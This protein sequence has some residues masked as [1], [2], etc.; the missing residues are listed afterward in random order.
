[1]LDIYFLESSKFWSDDS[2]IGQVELKDQYVCRA[3]FAK[4]L[5]CSEDAK[6]LTGQ[7]LVTGVERALKC[8]LEGIKVALQDSRYVFLLY[9]ASV[10]YW[11][12]SRPLQKSGT[13]RHLVDA[14]TSV[15]DALQKVSGHEE[16]KAHHLRIHAL[17]LSDAGK[18]ADALKVASDAVDLCKANVPELSVLAIKMKSHVSSL[19]G[20]KEGGDG[21]DGA[22]ALMQHVRSGACADIED[23]KNTLI[24]AWKL[25][26]PA[27]EK[28]EAAK[29]ESA[30]DAQLDVVAE[31]GWIAAQNQV[32]DLAAWCLERAADDSSLISRVRDEMTRGMIALHNL[33]EKRG[34]LDSEAIR[35]HKDVILE[36]EKSL[37]TFSR[38]QDFDGIHDACQMIW[39]ASLPLQQ[40]KFRHHLTR[41][42][43]AAALALETVGSSAN[44]LRTSLHLEL[45]YCYISEDMVGQAKAQVSKGLAIDYVAPAEEIKSTGYER[46]LDRFLDPLHR[47]L[48]LKSKIH[49]DPD[50]IED[51]ALLLAE[52][53]RDAKSV[54]SK[55]DIL[56]RAVDA[57]M[58]LQ[59]AT[60]P[61]ESD[62][63]STE[64]RE[65]RRRSARARINIWGSVIKVAMD[66]KQI[67]MVHR[68]AK[69]VV[70]TA[71]WDLIK[72]KD[73]ILLQADVNLLDGLASF[74]IL[75]SRGE[76]IIPPNE[77]N[78][79]VTITTGST[80]ELQNNTIAAFVR[81]MHLGA[82]VG[83]D[84]V[85]L[86]AAANVW[87]NYLDAFTAHRYAE[88]LPATAPVFAEL[89]KV[90]CCDE[91]LLGNFADALSCGYEHAAF[92]SVTDADDTKEDGMSGYNSL[93]LTLRDHKFEDSQDVKRGIETC[94]SVLNRVD[95]RNARKL[96]ATLARLHASMGTSSE[97]KVEE[98][99]VAQVSAIIQRLTLPGSDDA[100]S[101]MLNEAMTL[102][103]PTEGEI[104]GDLETWAR[105]GETALKAKV[106]GAA[107]ECGK[108]AEI[109][110]NKL[111]QSAP[112]ISW[113]WG[114]VAESTFGCGILAL[115]RPDHQDQ[116]T[117]DTLRE[118]AFQHLVQAAKCGRRANRSDIVSYAAKHFWNSA[119]SYM[120]SA[121]TR[122]NI[123]GHLQV[124][125]DACR[126]TKVR[127]DG[128][129]KLMWVLYFDCLVDK[130]AWTDG[131]K[132][133]DEA[134][135]MLP[136]SD[137][138]R[139]WEYKVLFL[140]ATGRKA[141]DELDMLSSYDEET[142][143]KVW[144][145]VAVQATSKLE[146]M[147]AYRKAIDVLV[148][149]TAMRVD[150]MID[151]ADWMYAN[152]Q[153]VS[154]AEDLL[155]STL[156]ILL[157]TDA[158]S[159]GDN[160]DCESLAT[161]Q[162]L[163]VTEFCFI[164]RVCVM[165]SRMSGSNV[166]RT[167]YLLTAQHY[168]LRM[169]LDPLAEA[170]RTMPASNIEGCAATPE[171]MEEWANFKF[172]DKLVARLRER[173][174]TFEISLES[175]G[176]PERILHYIDYL[177]SGLESA[178]MHLQCLPVCQL[179]VLIA[180][181]VAKD[182]S[183]AS[184]YHL[185]LASL[186][187]ALCLKSAAIMHEELA[188]SL[189]LSV[190]EI[191][192]GREEV[193]RQESLKELLSD[194]EPSSG[195]IDVSKPLR[196]YAL[197]DYWIARGAYLEKRGALV[198]ANIL[199][200]ETIRHARA[201]DDVA[202]EARAY[203]HLAK[204][205]ARGNMPIDAVKLQH[206]GQTLGGD[207]FFWGESMCDYTMYKLSTRDGKL[208]AKDS[209]VTALNL[210]QSRSSSSRCGD[211]LDTKMVMASLLTELSRILELEIKNAIEVGENPRAQYTDAVNAISEAVAI[212]QD[213]G[214]GMD[215]VNVLMA[216]AMLM[217]K[218]PSAIGDPRPGLRVIKEIIFEAET[219]AERIYTAA[220]VSSINPLT[221]SLPAARLL[222]AV[223]NARAGCLL[224]IAHAEKVLEY[225]DREN[226]RP[227]FPSIHGVDA[228]AILAFL[229]DSA[230]E[231]FKDTLNDAEEA[232]VVASEATN[233]H[234]RDDGRI[235]SLC[236]LGEALLAVHNAQ[237]RTKI[238]RKPPPVPPPTPPPPPA[239][240][241]PD[242]KEEEAAAEAG[243][244]K[245]ESEGAETE[246]VKPEQ[247]TDDAPE[248]DRQ[249]V[250]SD[251]ETD[252]PSVGEEDEEE[253]ESHLPHSTF[254]GEL[255]KPRAIRSLEQAIQFGIE[256]CKYDIVS[257][258][259]MHLAHAHGSADTGKAAAAL[260][261][262]QSCQ[263][264]ETHLSI[265]I[266][267]A[268]E[269]DI[270]SLII[271]NDRIIQG[272]LNEMTSSKYSALLFERLKT[273]CTAW[274]KLQ[275][276]AKQALS[277]SSTLP[278]DLFVFSLQ[279]LVG[280]GGDTSLAIAMHGKDDER[281]G[282]YVVSANQE[283]LEA[284]VQLTATYRSSVEKAVIAA[285]SSEDPDAL[286]SVFESVDIVAGWDEVR[287]ATEWVLEPIISAWRSFLGKGGS[288]E[289]KIV[290]L[291]DEALASLPIEA[292]E[293]LNDAESISR[294]FSL[295]M[296]SNRLARGSDITAAHMTALIDL[297]KEDLPQSDADKI[298]IPGEFALL[299][300]KF[301]SGWNVLM[302]T[303]ESIPGEAECQRAMAAAKAL[304]Y[305]GHGRFLSYVSPSA[306][307]SVDL[308]SCRL[309]VL[310][311][312]TNNEESQRMQAMLDGRKTA[313]KKALEEPYRTAALLSMRGVE[314]IVLPSFTVG[315]ARANSE[316]LTSVL[317]GGPVA[318]SVWRADTPNPP[319]KEEE[320][321][322]N[323]PEG[324][325]VEEPEEGANAEGEDEAGDDESEAVEPP[326]PP[327]PPPP[328][329]GPYRTYVI[330]GHPLVKIS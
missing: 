292:L 287:K 329:R 202:V 253:E 172:T 142:Q 286:Q 157:E 321:E 69:N 219:E 129:M 245:E 180:K 280:R 72:D 169:L 192:R 86:N 48:S 163:G 117:Q 330:Y 31:I 115:I 262:V 58:S 35:V 50:D 33:G 102:L 20:L 256:A 45:A 104:L 136:T 112:S 46:P 215:Y 82:S 138:Q 27:A 241:T 118:T 64:E 240:P 164:V 259:A 213:C 161:S 151:F 162:Q 137:H 303:P 285:S 294:D 130:K 124:I 147:K 276:D 80:E 21:V 5:V 296:L 283:Q 165:L 247:V 167:D 197:R 184:V 196:P 83:E 7:D 311:C 186:A 16:W 2:D 252:I 227:E 42:L 57:L 288:K 106:Y 220:C 14:S 258:A 322:E 270:E 238:W 307:A 277:A 149:N 153:P 123:F 97:A 194:D 218:D 71:G 116:S 199:L 323:E 65:M 59:P 233:L 11:N 145:G 6:G 81:A 278:D 24:E 325:E 230:P 41:V 100:S 310:A 8:L 291:V 216:K 254:R 281:T 320:I 226:N 284:A 266:S 203:L 43:G 26:D 212:L 239:P 92:L 208:S 10:H 189:E 269:Q 326:P 89:C 88:M 232:I 236:L 146:G 246:D 44:R 150:L 49:D 155:V 22:I 171:S 120:S 188:G 66:A 96:S 251:A 243:D 173:K 166:E 109:F 30:E 318:S 183:L 297:R 144:A 3:W 231:S 177:C 110:L 91:I 32:L 52:Q 94:E 74:D 28:L 315:N 267:A 264:V 185:R 248:G 18:N 289:K 56:Q 84:W 200:Q 198:A 249:S 223:K 257:K 293:F 38:L 314:S 23:V 152:G 121:T 125:I 53:A 306:V 156:D 101:D 309:A 250:V 191:R 111:T 275:I 39:I 328:P 304:L 134:F 316:F 214:G 168:A 76:P 282:A 300:Q 279:W 206:R 29:D 158:E 143:A 193:K 209:L 182:D 40:S 90:E 225:V 217:Y 75:R 295:H 141:E 85:V 122:R 272:A 190:E 55:T 271:K 61:S 73:I 25:V 126:A 224:E 140:S 302:G 181:I 68:L 131:I 179:G 228:T 317:G 132:Q 1:M 93:R 265:F 235:D 103:R 60:L 242:E 114:G 237:T 148:N 154:D 327:P 51:Q 63:M 67:S 98:D 211:T 319:R 70:D 261:L 313:D 195:V 13:R 204:C 268:D 78:T 222:A 229:D 290:L 263:A 260:A 34:T 105:L 135:K 324:K 273:S 4:A 77:I 95:E 207:V 308:S 234:K 87:N 47:M 305:Y 127:D 159:S 170:M 99:P 176:R 210:L 298:R 17:C 9:D 244:S 299:K 79:Q 301:G 187:D 19:E 119:T 15:N 54:E 205:A 128:L 108:Q 178:S 133:I 274:G 37:S 62:E 113:Y 175:V 160:M 139:L 12:I 107:I 174:G 201:H 255:V 221:T 36:A 312:N